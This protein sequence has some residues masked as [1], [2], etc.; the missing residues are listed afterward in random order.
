MIHEYPLLAID[1]FRVR[2]GELP[3]EIGFLTHM[4]ED[5]TLGLQRKSFNAPY[6]Y[7]TA[8]TK[9]M[10]LNYRTNHGH[11]RLKYAHLKAELGGKE[12][13]RALDVEKP[14]EL[15]YERETIE[16][17]L[18]PINH[19]PGSAMILVKPKY[20]GSAILFTGDMRCEPVDLTTLQ[21]TPA[22][23]PYLKQFSGTQSLAIYADA[24]YL[25]HRD[26]LKP[27]PQNAAGITGLLKVLKK[28]PKH[29]HFCT[30]D[31]CTG[32]EPVLIRL[33]YELQTK[34]HIDAYLFDYYRSVSPY[35]AMATEFIN[36][37]VTGELAK[38][39]RV[40]FCHKHNGC[41]ARDPSQ[42]SVY[43]KACNQPS[44]EA[45]DIQNQAVPINKATNLTPFGNGIFLSP[46]ARY[47]QY[48][49]AYLPLLV[50]YHFSRHASFPEI[51][52]FVALFNTSSVRTLE[53]DP[54]KTLDPRLLLKTQSIQRSTFN[55]DEEKARFEAFK[56]LARA[57]STHSTHSTHSV[58]CVDETP[59]F[60][61]SLETELRNNPMLW[62]TFGFDYA[63]RPPVP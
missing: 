1:D 32:H 38:S 62:Y 37:C 63:N 2:D 55:S 10:V 13:L 14:Y 33:A 21:R 49:D 5:H 48:K 45:L 4:H 29:T 3:A 60:A 50:S 18:I 44:Q 57:H 58:A 61:I 8:A 25:Q 41:F 39:A 9:Q 12:I 40:H 51:S 36:H 53:G 35:S 6:I 11:G 43:F 28:Y 46:K 16:V 19:C 20:L 34:I 22:L 54:L 26:P 31:L 56:L 24:T 15:A 23:F 42:P 47:Y 7:C 59:E 30:L 17:T 52:D 27:Y